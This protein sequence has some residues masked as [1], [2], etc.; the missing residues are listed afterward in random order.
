MINYRD[1]NSRVRLASTTFVPLQAVP[2]PGNA[3]SGGLSW[4]TGG[5]PA[6]REVLSPRRPACSCTSLWR[7][8][9]PYPLRRPWRWTCRLSTNPGG[10]G[11]SLRLRYGEADLLLDIRSI[12]SVAR[13]TLP[14]PT[15][16]SWAS[17]L[18]GP[19]ESLS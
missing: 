10:R 16:L 14:F 9:S 7:S 1:G 4:V 18:S 11:C 12:K 3:L 2:K 6:V 13:A 15:T 5:L 19:L 8:H 17:P